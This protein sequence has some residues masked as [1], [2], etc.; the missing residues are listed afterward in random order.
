MNGNEADTHGMAVVGA[1]PA[2]AAGDAVIGQ[3]TLP[4]GGPWTIFQLWALIASVTPLAAESY[5]GH[6]RIVAASGDLQPNPAPSRFPTGVVPSF[7]GAIASQVR[8]PLQIFDVDYE[9]A[10]KAVIDMVYNEAVAV[11]T[12]TQVVLGMIFGKTRP[13]LKP[14][15]FSD[16]LRVQI[17]LAADTAIG[18]LTLPEGATK[19]TGLCCQVAQSGVL[20][21]VEPII[22]FYRLSSDDIKMPPAQYPIN[23]ASAGLLGASTLALGSPKMVIIPVDIPVPGGARIDAFLDLNLALTAAAEIELFVMFE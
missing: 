18:T 17:L 16:W 15:K 8:N 5:G 3:I 12:A 23:G 4:A 22:G 2:G 11:T 13:V 14:H 21:V 7:L 10:G 20:T 1:G 19:I 6:F 9:A